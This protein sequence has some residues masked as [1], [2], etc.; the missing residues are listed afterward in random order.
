MWSVT[1]KI[2]TAVEANF[3]DQFVKAM[4]IPHKVSH[5]KLGTA[6]TGRNVSTRTSAAIESRRRRGA[7]PQA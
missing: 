3:R 2:E 7:P 4:A 5:E 6:V 1:S